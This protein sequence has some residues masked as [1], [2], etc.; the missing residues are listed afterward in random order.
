M[1]LANIYQTELYYCFE[2]KG[3][4]TDVLDEDSVIKSLDFTLYKDLKQSGQIAEGMIPKLDN[5]FNALH[6][7]VYKVNIGQPEMIFKSNSIFT[8]LKL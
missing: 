3:V 7:K 1:A 4:L 2:K 5:A 8:T 6:Q